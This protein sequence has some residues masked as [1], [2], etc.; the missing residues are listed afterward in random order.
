MRLFYLLDGLA[1][2]ERFIE[3]EIRGL[4]AAGVEL[5]VFTLKEA[6]ALEGAIPVP[7]LLSCRAAGCYLAGRLAHPVR[8]TRAMLGLL[9]AAGRQPRTL[10]AELLAAC[11][12]FWLARQLKREGARHLHAHFG[13]V[14]STAAWAIGRTFGIPYSVSVHAWDIFV[15]RS[16]LPEKLLGAELVVTC[17]RYA[18]EHLLRRWPALNAGKVVCVHHGIEPSDYE[19][20]PTP[21][22][23]ELKAVAVG[24]LVPKKGFDV[25]LRAAALLEVTP[26]SLTIVGDGPEKGRLAALARDLELGPRVRFAGSLPHEA[27]KEEISRAHVLVAPSVLA[28]GGDRD[29]LPNVVLEAMALG[30]PVV[31]S[32][33]SGLPE[34]VEDGRT[35]L[36]VKPGS[37]RALAGGLERLHENRAE[38]GRMGK[39]AR[40]SVEERFSLDLSTRRLL[41]AFRGA[42]VA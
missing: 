42:G 33:L 6:P 3:R 41:E 30:R 31:A 13:F 10:P 21:G 32:R 9:K 23:E 7:R 17:T 1:P 25:L 4:Q 19:A 18:R 36:L 28:R 24:R 15:N 40:E 11:R 38:L 16:L 37:A 5:S 20:R 35:G 26:V 34:A 22:G 39:E 2:T 14:A 8:A 27:V 12:A 29:G